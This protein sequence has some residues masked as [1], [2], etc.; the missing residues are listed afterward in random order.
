[1]E[2]TTVVA[3]LHPSNWEGRHIDSIQEGLVGAIM[4][5]PLEHET[6]S[7]IAPV[8]ILSLRMIWRERNSQ[9]VASLREEQRVEL[10][11]PAD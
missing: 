8:V 11:I 5:E 4:S 10:L 6:Q 9:S 3:V 7:S 2:W 1:M